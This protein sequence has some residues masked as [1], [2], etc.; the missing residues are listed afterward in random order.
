MI[1]NFEKFEIGH[2]YIYTGTY[3]PNG[4]CSNDSM[5][6]V[7]DHKPCKCIETYTTIY[8]AQFNNTNSIYNW[9][10]GFNNWIE[11]EDP[12]KPSNINLGNKYYDANTNLIKEAILHPV[13]CFGHPNYAL[14]NPEMKLAFTLD[15]WHKEHIKFTIPELKTVKFI[16]KKQTKKFI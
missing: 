3:S 7:L 8:N 5:E 16:V 13:Y 14:A 11:I 2:W 4:W 10:D 12:L 1:R 9:A 15:K 6:N